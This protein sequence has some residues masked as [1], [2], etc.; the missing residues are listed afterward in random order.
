MGMSSEL[1]AYYIVLLEGDICIASGAFYSGEMAHKVNAHTL[2]DKSA[3][4]SYTQAL[5]VKLTPYLG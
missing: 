5:C 4:A 3:F 2:E 1:L